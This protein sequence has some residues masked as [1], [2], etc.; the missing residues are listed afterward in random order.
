VFLVT[1]L[2]T[3]HNCAAT[4]KLTTYCCIASRPTVT[5]CCHPF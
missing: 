2:Q 4:W 5:A 1:Q 3:Y